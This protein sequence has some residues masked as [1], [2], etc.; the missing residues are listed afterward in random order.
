MAYSQ[1]ELI[2][3]LKENATQMSRDNIRKNSENLTEA[4]KGIQGNHMDY[5]YVTGMIENNE[6]RMHSIEYIKILLLME[7]KAELQP[8]KTVYSISIK[9]NQVC[10]SAVLALIDK[11]KSS[12]ANSM[13]IAKSEG[14]LMYRVSHEEKDAALKQ[15]NELNI[16]LEVKVIHDLAADN[17]SVELLDTLYG[18]T[19]EEYFEDK[20]EVLVEGTKSRLFI[21]DKREDLYDLLI[22]TGSGSFSPG[23]TYH[24]CLRTQVAYG[25]DFG[26]EG[27][28]QARSLDI[29]FK[30]TVLKENLDKTLEAFQNFAK[31]Q[32]FNHARSMGFV[33]DFESYFYVWAGDMIGDE[34]VTFASFE[35][36]CVDLLI[37]DFVQFSIKE[38]TTLENVVLYCGDSGLEML[39]F[40]NKGLNGTD[41]AIANYLSENYFEEGRE[42]RALDNIMAVT[43]TLLEDAIDT[44]IK[45][46]KKL[47]TNNDLKEFEYTQG[48]FIQHLMLHRVCARLEKGSDFKDSCKPANDFK[49]FI[50]FHEVEDY[51]NW[52]LRKHAAQTLDKT[53]E[54]YVESWVAYGIR[55]NIDVGFF[56]F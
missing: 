47:H 36:G 8:S 50:G 4:L 31:S 20:S 41:E 35:E 53:F 25:H 56:L 18:N 37:K 5:P 10:S 51:I 52:P 27:D 6:N 45:K 19:E 1:E 33:G 15:F 29:K 38:N 54:E 43:G 34:Q 42:C 7:S 12:S 32:G 2:L 40:N 46:N 30:P 11:T 24:D 9:E 16:E 14:P 3:R 48:V 44:I 13:S 23:N 22:Y 55:Q 39:Y 21:F 26:N 17:V 49:V 28:Y